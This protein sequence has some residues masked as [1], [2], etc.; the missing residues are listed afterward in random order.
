VKI[1]TAVAAIEAVDHDREGD[2]DV[3]AWQLEVEGDSSV[4]GL[5]AGD[6]FSMR[7]LLYG[8]L[9]PSGSDA[10]VAIARAVSGSEA[11]FVPRMNALAA[12]LGLRDTHFVD[13]D[14]LAD[15]GQ[16]SSAYD[17]ALLARFAMSFPA[18]RE[19]VSAEQWMAHGNRD[20]EL[21]NSNPLLGYT[22][23]VDGVK[24]GFTDGAGRTYVASATRDAHQIFVVLLNDQFRARDAIALIEWAFSAYR[25]HD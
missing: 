19:I 3:D 8:L 14:G 17:L 6:R 16:Y 12:R 13:P 4:M 21:L 1:A 15:V 18:F 5:E 2:I 10:A 11:G 20:I 23:G 7:D 9:L 25:W 24:T 22:P